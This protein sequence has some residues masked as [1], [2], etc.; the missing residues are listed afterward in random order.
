MLSGA[1][2]LAIFPSLEVYTIRL[3]YGENVSC[4]KSDLLGIFQ[5]IFGR[6]KGFLHKIDSTP[7]IFAAIYGFCTKSALFGMSVTIRLRYGENAPT[8]N[9]LYLV[10]PIYIFLSRREH[11]NYSLL[12]IHYSFIKTPDCIIGSFLLQ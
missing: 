1:F 4:T 5:Y 6:R 7:Y 10:I 2:L 8:L 9:L 11:L 3:R 12:G